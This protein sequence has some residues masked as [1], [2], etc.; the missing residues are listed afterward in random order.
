MAGFILTQLSLSVTFPQHL[1][2]LLTQLNNKVLRLSKINQSVLSRLLKRFGLDLEITK[3]SQPIPGSYWGDEEAGLLGNRLLARMDTPLHS[4]LHEAG[5]YICMDE[6]RRA[7]LDT[8]AEGDYDEENA[9]CYL[10]ILLAEEIPESG[11]N[12]MFLDMDTW[13]YTFRLG[14]AMSW[15]EQD[16]EDTKQWLLDCGLITPS[17]QPSYQL[18]ES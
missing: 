5:H 13:G 1:K 17:G 2:W 16:S 7:A 14:S 3:D 4:I 8:N 15:F 10:Q 9:V 18:R 12:R 11:R 6:S